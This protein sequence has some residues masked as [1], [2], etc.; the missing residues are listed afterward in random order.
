MYPINK[1]VF[2]LTVCDLLLGLIL[3]ATINHYYP[4]YTEW[5]FR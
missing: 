3:G 1:L 2:V 4:E 5:L